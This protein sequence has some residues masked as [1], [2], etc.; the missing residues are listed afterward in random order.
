MSVLWV[1]RFHWSYFSAAQRYK[2]VN[3]S[4]RAAAIW[5][6][7]WNILLKIV[8]MALMMNEV[9]EWGMLC[10]VVCVCLGAEQLQQQQQQHL[11]FT[12]I[13]QHFGSI[14]I[15]PVVMWLGPFLFI[16]NACCF[17]MRRSVTWAAH[18]T[19][20]RWRLQVFFFSQNPANTQS[21]NSKSLSWTG[22]DLK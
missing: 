19:K 13:L 10:F 5:Y 21:N 18:W 20:W 3:I 6:W 15:I 11:R 1:I 2:D 17:E 14:V 16:F 9:I 22:C 8:E 7:N 12:G 4:T